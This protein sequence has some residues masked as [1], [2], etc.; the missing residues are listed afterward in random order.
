METG[1]VE[2]TKAFEKAKPVIDRE[3]NGVIPRFFIRILVE[4]E[5]AINEMWEDREGRKKM[6]KNNSKSLGALRQKLRKYIKDFEEDMTKFRENPDAADDDE[7]DKDDKDADDDDDDDNDEEDE[8]DLK[9]EVTK[10]AF[11][12]KS[13]STTPA[14]DDESDDDDSYWGSSSDESS[15]SSSDDQP[16]MSLREKFLKKTSSKDDDKKSKKEKKSDKSRKRQTIIDEEEEDEDEDGWTKVDHG[17]VDKPKMF[18]KDAEINHDLVVKKLRE[19]MAARGRKRTNRKEQIELLSELHNISEEHKL[20]VGISVKIK[21]AIIAGIFDYNPK[22]SAAMKPE[23]WEKCM[24]EVESLL[25]VIAENPDLQIGDGIMEDSESLEKT[26]Y[27]VRGCFLAVVERL[28][29]EFHKVLKSCDAHSNEYVD[30]LKDEDRVMEILGKAEAILEKTQTPSEMCR[31]YLQRIDHIYFK[32]DPDVIKQRNVSLFNGFSGLKILSKMMIR[33]VLQFRA[34]FFRAVKSTDI[35]KILDFYDFFQHF[36]G[37]VFDVFFYFSEGNSR[38]S[39]NESDPNVQDVQIHLRQGRY[40]SFENSS[41]S[42]SYLPPCH[43]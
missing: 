1:F 18:D 36:Q 40:G 31:I 15:S 4:L 34:R 3:E 33:N 26:P 41:H 17:A 32:F 22:I 14:D 16:G 5:D 13:K 39:G 24:P 30:R 29:E 8:E 20:G 2:L 19:I 6:S 37:S 9:P 10:D 12:K 7:A 25:A 23:Y 11:K 27:R 21:F 42:M 43:S 28:N 35:L 38:R